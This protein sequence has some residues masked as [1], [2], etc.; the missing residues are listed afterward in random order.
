MLFW[1]VFVI[2]FLKYLIRRNKRMAWLQADTFFRARFCRIRCKFGRWRVASFWAE[3]P[4]RDARR[5]GHQEHAVP[6]PVLLSLQEPRVQTSFNGNGRLDSSRALCRSQNWHPHTCFQ[7]ILAP[8]YPWPAVLSSRCWRGYKKRFMYF[9][10]NGMKCIYCRKCD[11]GGG[12][13][14]DIFRHALWTWKRHLTFTTPY[15]LLPSPPCSFL[16]FC[17]LF[18]LPFLT[19][20]CLWDPCIVLPFSPAIIFNNGFVQNKFRL[21]FPSESVVYSWY[22]LIAF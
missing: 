1:I 3:R 20:F 16:A 17:Y 13:M 19:L 9:S 6:R 8:L 12:V 7:L 5:R 15:L 4:T 2:F 18:S 10:W 21:F 14:L 22:C 11:N